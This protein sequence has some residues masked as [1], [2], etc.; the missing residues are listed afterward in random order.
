[1]KEKSAMYFPFDFLRE[2]IGSRL[3]L[4]SVLSSLMVSIPNFAILFRSFRLSSALLLWIS[5][6]KVVILF[7]TTKCFSVFNTTLTFAINIFITI[8]S[9]I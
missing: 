3:Y 1:M 5:D 8:R 9:C 6:A 2:P 4:I 7:Q